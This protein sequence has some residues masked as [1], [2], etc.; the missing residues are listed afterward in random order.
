[1][2]ER[3]FGHGEH[4]DDVSVEG[5]FGYVEVNFGYVCAGFLHGG[6]GDVSLVS[7]GHVIVL[8]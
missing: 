1:M 3:V 7:I 4:G 5:L 2:F 6:C 8:L